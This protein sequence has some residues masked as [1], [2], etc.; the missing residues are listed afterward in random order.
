MATRLVP[1]PLREIAQADEGR[2]WIVDQRLE[3]IETLTPVRGSLT[4]RHLGS[5]L[6]LDADVETI[7]TLRC[8]RCLNRFNR[9]LCFRG[10]ELIA[11]ESAPAGGGDPWPSWGEGDELIERIGAG[12][13]FDPAQWLFEQLHLQLAVVNRCGEECTGPPQPPE[14]TAARRLD[15]RWQALAGLGL[16]PED[17]GDG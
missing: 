17:T 6:E 7:V 9:S 15:P 2:H 5:A 4:A 16:L 12:E 13:R 11:I 1:V 8:D 10:R 3:G 14:P